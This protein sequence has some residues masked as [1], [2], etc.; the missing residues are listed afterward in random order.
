MIMPVSGDAPGEQDDDEHGHVENHATPQ[1][2][3]VDE[4]ALRDDGR[5]AQGSEDDGTGKSNNNADETPIGAQRLVSAFADG[6]HHVQ[7]HDQ[8]R[9]CQ[10][11]LQ[12]RYELKQHHHSCGV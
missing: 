4:R 9:R 10:Q 7:R 5:G 2:R 8:Q 12:H 1:R 11:T 3:I 6:K